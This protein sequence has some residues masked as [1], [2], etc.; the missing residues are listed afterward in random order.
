MHHRKLDI[1]SYLNQFHLIHTLFEIQLQ[2]LKF[3]QDMKYK[4]LFIVNE[5]LHISKRSH[6]KRKLHPGRNICHTLS[7]N[8]EDIHHNRELHTMHHS[9]SSDQPLNHILSASPC[10]INAVSIPIQMFMMPLI[11]ADSIEQLDS[12]LPRR[13]RTSTKQEHSRLLNSSYV[14]LVPAATVAYN[15]DNQNHLPSI[16]D[17]FKQAALTKQCAKNQFQHNFKTHWSSHTEN[18]TIK[19]GRP[20]F[21]IRNP[22]VV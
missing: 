5:K 3:Y 9:N 7:V 18:E 1:V 11:T 13:T 16:K 20:R 10:P 4:L 15:V 17:Y 14:T 22:L 21:Q 8:D 6:F 2:F 19:D 12:S